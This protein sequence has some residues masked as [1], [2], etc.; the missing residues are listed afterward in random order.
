MVGYKRV[1]SGDSHVREPVDLWWK[2]MGAKFGDRTPRAL[3]E[4]DGRKGKFFFSGQRVSK[5]G[6]T[7]KPVEERTE[8][9]DLIVR[10]GYDSD[11]RV[12]FQKRAGIAAEIM[13]PS[14]TAQIIA[15][16]DARVAQ[17]ACQ[18]YNDWIAEFCSRDF[19]RLIGVAVIPIHDIDWAI[20]EV[21]RTAAKGLRGAMI[22]VTPPPGA[23]PY[24]DRAYDP[25]WTICQD[26][27]WPVIL[28]IITGQAV[29]PLV[30]FHNERDFLQAAR[31]M[32][33]VWNEIQE[34]LSNDFIFGQILDRFPKLKILCGEY[35]VSWLP[36]FMFRMDQ[37]QDDFKSFIKLPPL[38]HRASDYI[39]TRIYHGMVDDPYA[40]DGL[41]RVGYGQVLWGS[42]FP[43]VR[44]IGLDTQPRLAEMLGNLPKD[45]QEKIVGGNAARLFNI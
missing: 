21:R 17:A 8:E 31:H 27:D 6:V 1:I 36:H 26:N 22:N 40:M 4:H 39:R 20:A 16:E 34:T 10:S 24:V 28:H 23:R 32:F 25:L 35:E 45:A 41:T 42:D 33:A 18:V 15:I 30:Y 13:Y 14:L 2:A 29:D 43:H 3:D 12:E 5:Y 19:K 9:D 44:S 7:E 11:V 38:K 37:V